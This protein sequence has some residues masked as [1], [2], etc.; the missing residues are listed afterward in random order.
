MVDTCHC[1]DCCWHCVS[2]LRVWP[3]VLLSVT[4]PSH[5]V[6]LEAFRCLTKTSSRWTHTVSSVCVFGSKKR[7]GNS[8]IECSWDDAWNFIKLSAFI[9]IVFHHHYDCFP[10]CWIAGSQLKPLPDVHV[11][12]PSQTFRKCRRAKLWNTARISNYCSVSR[13]LN[14]IL[15]WCFYWVLMM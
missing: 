13:L 9:F 2:L 4:S 1:R 11:H 10:S 3:Q 15:L 6:R 8:L 7:R 14:Y 12:H 5:S